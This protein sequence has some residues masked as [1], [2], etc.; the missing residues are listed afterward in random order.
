MKTKIKYAFH[1]VTNI[2]RISFDFYRQ[3]VKL[4]FST[5]KLFYFQ[6]HLHI[7]VSDLK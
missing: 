5:L 1:I 6:K 2:L 4:R 7:L 3:K